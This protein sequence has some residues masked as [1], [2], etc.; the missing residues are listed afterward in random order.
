MEKSLMIFLFLLITFNLS[1]TQNN[2][3]TKEYVLYKDSFSNYVDLN[4]FIY[5]DNSNYRVE[6]IKIKDFNYKLNNDYKNDC[7]PEF[8]I[9]NDTFI[10]VL[11]NS[12]RRLLANASIANLVAL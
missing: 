8:T 10:F 12:N 7:P 5:D 2:I 3:T 1:F 11:F 6:F 9:I 4:D